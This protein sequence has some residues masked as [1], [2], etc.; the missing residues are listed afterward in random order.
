MNNPGSLGANPKT[1]G[2]PKNAYPNLKAA[3]EGSETSNSKDN[4]VP[5]AP[6]EDNDTV[7]HETSP[8]DYAQ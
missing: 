3:K 8:P 4:T 2:P 7:E 1:K 6:A 5:S